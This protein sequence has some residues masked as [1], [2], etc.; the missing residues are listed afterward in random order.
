MVILFIVGLVGAR[1]ANVENFGSK[2][3]QLT[4]VEE[5]NQPKNRITSIETSNTVTQPRGSAATRRFK[6]GCEDGSPVLALTTSLLTVD[7][8]VISTTLT[9]PSTNVP[10]LTT[11][12]VTING[13]NMATVFQVA[14]TDLNA[15]PTNIGR[16]PVSPFIPPNAEAE[17]H[18][19]SPGT[20]EQVD[21]PAYIPVQ[22]K[23][24]PG[25]APPNVPL[26]ESPVTTSPIIGQYDTV[27][28][29]VAPGQHSPTD[30]VPTDRPLPHTP[31]TDIPLSIP[32]MATTGHWGPPSF[33]IT[34]VTTSIDTPAYANPTDLVPTFLPDQDHTKLPPHIWRVKA[35]DA[36]TMTSEMQHIDH[37]TRS[38]V[39]IHTTPSPQ[40]PIESPL[41]DKL[42]VRQNTAV[43]SLCEMETEI[44]DWSYVTDSEG[45][46]VSTP[47]VP[48]GNKSQR[49]AVSSATNTANA[50]STSAITI[51]LD[52][53]TSTS[54][55]QPS[56]GNALTYRINVISLFYF[57]MVGCFI[58]IRGLLW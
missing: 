57:I 11:A 17:T 29:P 13:V 51:L 41:T 40:S 32:V 7:G 46:V 52:W 16:A 19:A 6:R 30:A 43:A 9:I 44:S 27:P 23:P 15:E 33:S 53:P 54:T 50:S 28:T 48:T 20:H 8:T 24:N 18:I 12:L 55:S 2:H 34:P 4:A 14:T 3:R 21:V 56:A 39:S 22:P 1:F 38:Q 31:P 35:R 5:S 49:L 10:L 25:V 42:L 37:T 45:T 36:V 47:S 58:E 26:V